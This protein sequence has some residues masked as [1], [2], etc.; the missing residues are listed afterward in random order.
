VAVTTVSTQQTTPI[1][2]LTANSQHLE[3]TV[4]SGALTSLPS[5]PPV[6]VLLINHQGHK[7]LATVT[8]IKSFGNQVTLTVNSLHQAQN[9]SQPGFIPTN[10][11]WLSTEELSSELAKLT[12]GNPLTLQLGSHQPPIQLGTATVWAKH[13]QPLA[14]SGNCL[15]GQT[16]ILNALTQHKATGI[17]IDPT[18]KY[19]LNTNSL[20]Y[21]PSQL[22]LKRFNL[23]QLIG[24]ITQ[25]WPHPWVDSAITQ[26]S[27]S[28]IHTLGGACQ[29]IVSHLQQLREPLSDY[30]PTQTEHHPDS[31]LTLN[32]LI[33]HKTG[34][35]HI[36][37]SQ[38][39]CKLKT[40]VMATLLSECQ[41]LSSEAG[42]IWV[43]ATDDQWPALK[44][45]NTSVIGLCPPYT[46]NTLEA[47]SHIQVDYAWPLSSITTD[48]VL[49]NQD[50][51]PSPPAHDVVI[52]AQ[53]TLTHGLALKYTVAGEALTHYQVAPLP[54]IETT[55]K[56]AART[57]ATIPDNRQAEATDNSPYEPKPDTTAPN[58]AIEQDISLSP[59]PDIEPPATPAVANN[60]IEVIADN[61]QIDT[62]ESITITPASPDIEDALD[63][64]ASEANSSVNDTL[65]D[66]PLV[67]EAPQQP[68]VGTHQDEPLSVSNHIDF[69]LP[70]STSSEGTAQPTP[71]PAKP[72]ISKPAPAAKPATTQWAVGQ[73]IHHPRYGDGVIEGL[74]PTG[75][76][77]TLRILFETV[78]KRLLDADQSNLQLIS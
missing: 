71:S 47:P 32:E 27:H 28:S 16:V 13:G 61:S 40:V 35:H 48:T 34:W 41:K 17:I 50:D 54:Y 37:L 10:L 8:A 78:G 53:G 56:H 38:L 74:T 66:I 72:N 29:Q 30:L 2:G 49:G 64:L 44:Q 60:P 4:E 15:A 45:T 68:N 73:K 69:D 67:P 70:N 19:S 24:A 7:Q 77:T 55:L 42:I 65:N 21:H 6:S 39:P 75:K 25:H 20:P 22:S 14:M 11:T 76:R 63:E 9:Q 31:Q 46:G 52:A 51:Q 62:A 23:A 59:S 1:L 36:D 5:L 3:L 43:H 58:M 12:N 26:L 18:G 57:A 33:T